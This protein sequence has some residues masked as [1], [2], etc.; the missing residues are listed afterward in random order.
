MLQ[1]NQITI[2]FGTAEARRLNWAWMTFS[3]PPSLVEVQFKRLPWNSPFH[4][5]RCHLGTITTQTPY[6]GSF[7]HGYLQPNFFVVDCRW[8][9]YEI[10]YFFFRIRTAGTVT[11]TNTTMWIRLSSSSVVAI[12]FYL[13]IR[14]SFLCE[15]PFCENHPKMDRLE[16]MWFFPLP[17]FRTPVIKLVHHFTFCLSKSLA[18]F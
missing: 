1:S 16:K 13:C 9:I 3:D 10:T 8:E 4:S 5:S 6:R 18:C 11:K 14:A 2:K 7:I 17:K 12:F 15:A